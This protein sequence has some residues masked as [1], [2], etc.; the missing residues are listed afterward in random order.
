MT[1]SVS[2]DNAVCQALIGARASTIVSF[3]LEFFSA[4]PL[5]SMKCGSNFVARTFRERSV[6]SLDVKPNAGGGVMSAPI[7]FPHGLLDFGSIVMT[8]SE[9]DRH[10]GSLAVTTAVHLA[11]GGDLVIL[12]MSLGDVYLRDAI[13]QNRRWI[14][15]IY[16]L[17]EQFDHLEWARVANVT[18]VTAPNDS[19]WTTLSDAVLAND[20]SGK[21]AGWLPKLRDQLPATYNEMKRWPEKTKTALHDFGQQLASS[22][23]AS[24]EHVT[25]FASHCIDIGIEVPA[26]VLADARCML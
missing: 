21:M 24:A 15:N 8:K 12:G 6:Y 25:L 7:Y 20:D 1:A 11:I 23:E 13:L 10:Q 19:V 3:N 14:R 9:Y 17:A 18:L 16:W 22:A 26:E 4:F 5:V 2:L